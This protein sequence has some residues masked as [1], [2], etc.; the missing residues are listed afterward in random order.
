[1]TKTSII[2]SKATTAEEGKRLV[3]CQCHCCS[4]RKEKLELIPS[5]DR[6]R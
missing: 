4:A 3:V 6:D 1:M 2:L 5:I